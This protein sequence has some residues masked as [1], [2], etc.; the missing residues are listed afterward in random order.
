[1]ILNDNVPDCCLVDPQIHSKEV[2]CY[3]N[4]HYLQN[5][6]NFFYICSLVLLVSVYSEKETRQCSFEE[7]NEKRQDTHI[8]LNDVKM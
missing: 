8:H 1:M 5:R 7:T 4:K 2:Q 6:L 3:G